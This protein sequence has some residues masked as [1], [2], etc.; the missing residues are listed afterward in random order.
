MHHEELSTIKKIFKRAY[1]KWKKQNNGN[2]ADKTINWMWKYDYI[3]SK[4]DEVTTITKN[5]HS[6]HT[7]EKSKNKSI[8]S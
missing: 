1:I 2:R 7:K 4:S 5:K 6:S 8:K 3:L